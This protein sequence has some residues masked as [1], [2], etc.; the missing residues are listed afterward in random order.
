MISLHAKRYKRHPLWSMTRERSSRTAPNLLVLYTKFKLELLLKGD[1]G[2][3]EEGGG[4]LIRFSKGHDFLVRLA[5]DISRLLRMGSGGHH[6]STLFCRHFHCHHSI[7]A[8]PL[9]TIFAC[10]RCLP[11]RITLIGQITVSHSR[12]IMLLARGNVFRTVHLSTDHSWPIWNAT[13]ATR[14]GIF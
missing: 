6:S 2:R 8:T 13:I 9:H 4:A 10:R 5:P 3:I 14:R 12:R 7:E 1:A 11:I